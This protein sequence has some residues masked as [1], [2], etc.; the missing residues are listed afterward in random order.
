MAD[1]K[2]TKTPEPCGSCRFRAEYGTWHCN[3]SDI[4]GVTKHR[5]HPEAAPGALAGPGCL[6][7]QRGRRMER[8]CRVG[9][10]KPRPERPQAALSQDA[11]WE[12]MRAMHRQGGNDVQIA[13]EMGCSVSAV[14]RWRV[15]QGLPP[16]S[17]DGWN[18]R[19]ERRTDNG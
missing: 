3:Y 9:R 12:S 17:R 16:N 13:R 1:P 11:R 15:R 5:M 19:R 8:P 4:M 2:Y 6:C 10:K 7:Y 18:K 14:R